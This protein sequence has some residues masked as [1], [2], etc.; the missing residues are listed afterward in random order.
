MP[1]GQAKAARKLWPGALPVSRMD[2][3]F[4]LCRVHPDLEPAIRAR[5]EQASRYASDYCETLARRFLRRGASPALVPELRHFY[6]LTQRGK[7]SHIVHGRA[8]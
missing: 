2:W 6:R 3:L 7:L 4:R 1:E 8:S 5:Y